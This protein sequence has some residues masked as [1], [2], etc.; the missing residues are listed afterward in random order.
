MIESQQLFIVAMCIV[1]VFSSLISFMYFLDYTGVAS[2]ML[3]KKKKKL[4]EK[5][6]FM[7]DVR[8]DLP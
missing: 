5:Y 2:K 8:K 4:N 7:R 1:S 3:T 6:I